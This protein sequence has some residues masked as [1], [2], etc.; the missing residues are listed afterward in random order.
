MNWYAYVGNDPINMTDPTGEKSFLVSRPLNKRHAIKSHPGSFW[1][2][3]NFI[4]IYA[5]YPGD[6]NATIISYGRTDSGNMGRV[7]H[8][9]HIADRNHWLSLRNAETGATYRE[10]DAADST[11]EK[12]AN[13]LVENNE[14]NYIPELQGGVN[15][16]TGAGAVAQGSDGGAPDVNNGI[17]Q[18]GSS[19]TNR[20]SFR[21]KVTCI[22]SR[23]KKTSC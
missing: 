11:V 2:N 3:H 16:N 18:P 17:L 6:K 14:Y 10:I 23:I 15:S 20:V 21:D 9:V 4:V 1:P 22:G 5:D 8:D 12:L 7:Y 13:S 19:V